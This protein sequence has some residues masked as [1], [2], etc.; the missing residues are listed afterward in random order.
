MARK[1]ATPRK[2]S[3]G[4]R[5]PAGLTAY[6]VASTHWDREWYEPFQ[7]YRFRLVDVI[8]G[9]LDLLERDPEYRAYQLDGQTC[10]L[11]D[12]LEIRPEHRARLKKHVAAGRIQIGPWYV[13]PDEFIPC[14]E[15]LVRNLLRGHRV[16]G[17]FGP[18]MKVGFVCDIFGHNSQLPQIFR[19]FGIAA[20]AVW[21]GTNAPTHPALFRWQGADG[22]EVL[23]YAYEDRGYGQYQFE[24]RN[25]AET[26]TGRMNLNKALEGL[27]RCVE[28][29]RARTPGRAVLLFDGIDHVPVEPD[30]SKLLVRARRAGLNIVHGTLADF[31]ADVRRQKLKLQRF[32]GELRDPGMRKNANV[33]PGVVSSRMYLKQY[34]ARCENRLLHWVEPFAALASLL[35]EEYPAAY[36]DRAWKYLLLN[37]PHD[38]IC[39]CSID[40]VHRDM[41]HRFDQ[42]RLIADRACQMSLRA[43]ADRTPLPKLA[44]EED[45]VVTVFNPTA[46]AR[47]E[48]FDLP[49]YFRRDTENRYQ[50]W[51]GY[52]PII[53]FRLF[54]EKGREVPY[55]RLD[56]T[57]SVPLRTYDRVAGYRGDKREQVRVAARLALPPCGWTT[58]VCRPTAEPTRSVGSQLIDDHTMDNEHL[59]VAVN[60]NGTIDVCEL[61]S[62]ELYG[63]LLTLEERADI[64]DGWFHGT[65][66]NDEIFTSV[67]TSADIALVHD[68]FARTTFRVRVELHVPEEFVF[69]KEVMRRSPRL[70]PLVVTHWVTLRA[71]ARHVE[72]HTEVDNTVRDH[73]LRVLLP[74]HLHTETYF[75]DSPYDVIK[76]KITLRPD[77]HL[78]H[79]PEVETKPQYSFTAVHDTQRG[80]AVISTGQP[81]SAVCDRPDRPLALTLFRGFARTVENEGDVEGQML[82]KT[83]HDY[84]IYPHAG[85]LP[86]AD[87]LRLGRRLATG[88]ECIYT[89]SP[90]LERLRARPV[91]PATGSWLKP[92]PGPLIV[93]AAKQ[94]EDGQAVIVRAFNPTGKTVQQRFEFVVPVKAA[95]VANLLEE[96]QTPVT[97]RGKTVTVEANPKEIVTLRLE[98]DNLA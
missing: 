23:T 18:V 39:G 13:M 40:Q 52:E 85:P 98:L 17:E 56:V 49:L 29:E 45:F 42:S 58:L 8:D 20:A 88:V 19:G 51:F 92:G 72:I 5:R 24:V 50:E 46:E 35:G 1:K 44:G 21:R 26:P 93:T 78:L 75:A 66:V 91:L 37:H 96:P 97:R 36:L 28:I 38:S 34:N 79:E 81:E 77:S 84:W 6:Y 69:D 68:G 89:E 83:A 48:V 4:P 55:Q 64:G 15:S 16:A 43:I 7:H 71:G 76:R 22:S 67:G 11:E 14:G 3:R 47:D 12:Y 32:I 94:S 82:G 65:A 61:A 54:D 63:D 2:T 95:H 57:K 73:R 30:T 86:V 60:S 90:R 59:R 10:V 70:V 87:L 62:G 80:L 9:A 31:F 53:G 74:T 27:D 41:M 25:P 33:I